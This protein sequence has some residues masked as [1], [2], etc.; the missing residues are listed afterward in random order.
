MLGKMVV[1]SMIDNH[2]NTDK[3][4]NTWWLCIIIVMLNWSSEDAHYVLFVSKK[5]WS[6][7]VL[8]CILVSFL[9]YITSVLSV[10]QTH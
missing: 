5:D 9:N 1:I 4:M 2:G 3:Q 6:N 7:A 10:R 8:F